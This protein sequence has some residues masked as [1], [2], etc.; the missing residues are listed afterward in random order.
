MVNTKHLGRILRNRREALGLTLEKTAELSDMS[1]KG[2][3]GI[4]LG[5]SDPKFSTLCKIAAALELDLGELNSCVPM[6]V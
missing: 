5:D 6:K 2:Y 4:E 3:E 1:Y